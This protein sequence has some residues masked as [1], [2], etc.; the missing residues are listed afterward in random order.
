MLLHTY[1]TEQAGTGESKILY[2]SREK[3]RVICLQV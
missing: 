1:N 2:K 3:N